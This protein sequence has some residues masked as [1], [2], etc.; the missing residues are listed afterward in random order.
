MGRP[1]RREGRQNRCLARLYNGR[2]V[3]LVFIKHISPALSQACDNCDKKCVVSLECCRN[4]T[5]KNCSVPALY[6]ISIMK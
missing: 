2:D 6:R 1:G 4:G 5:S 3:L